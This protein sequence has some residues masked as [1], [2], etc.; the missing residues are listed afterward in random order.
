MGR[1]ESKGLVREEY[2]Q[3]TEEENH[4]K[5]LDEN[6]NTEEI[7]SSGERCHQQRFSSLVPI[8]VRS[9]PSCQNIFSSWNNI[10]IRASSVLR[11]QHV[12]KPPSPISPEI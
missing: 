1:R 9:R 11:Q 5:L 6:D 7:I 10:L 8:E 4:E 2:E 12:I 3:K